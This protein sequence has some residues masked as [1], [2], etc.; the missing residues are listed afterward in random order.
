MTGLLVEPTE[1]PFDVDV[2]AAVAEGMPLGAV[3]ARH[4]VSEE[5]ALAAL[6]GWRDRIATMPVYGTQAVQG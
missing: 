5:A 4:G 3:L 2:R 6:S 1:D